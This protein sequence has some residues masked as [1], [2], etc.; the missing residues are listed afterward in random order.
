MKI[1]KRLLRWLLGGLLL[2]LVLASGAFVVWGSTPLGPTDAAL[3]ALTSEGPVTVVQDRWLAFQPAGQDPTTGLVFYPG[4]RV[5]PRS[6]APLA[7]EIAARGHLVVIVPMPLNLA[8]L[9]PDRADSVIAAYPSV[10]LWALGGHSLGGAMAAR[11]VYQNEQAVDGLVLWAA[12]PASTDDLSERRD[13]AVLSVTAT[14]DGLMTD[15]EL[16]N[17]REL[18]PESTCWVTI[19]GGN[20]AQFGS[21][22]PQR[23]DNPATIPQAAQHAAVVDA[24]A[25]FLA[26]LATSGDEATDCA[27]IGGAE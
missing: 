24:T 5:D 13:L 16:S 22:G 8:V 12:Y 11:Y 14:R 18:L 26:S 1:H 9:A 27:G 17:S 4:G 10:G 3:A 20:H 7:W 21:Y 25:S 15:E 6:Y 19:E 23:G 2:T